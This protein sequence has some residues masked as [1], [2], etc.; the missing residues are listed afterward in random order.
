[1]APKYPDTEG[2]IKDIKTEVD[3]MNT[4]LYAVVVIL[5][6]MV[7]N[8]LI[9]SWNNKKASLENFANQLNQQNLNL[10]EL[11][12]K[13]N[14]ETEINNKLKDLKTKNPYLKI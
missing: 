12:H 5:L 1:M 11:N 14:L 13:L 10:Q 2:K 7:G 4:L 3:R 9:D 6:F 8:M